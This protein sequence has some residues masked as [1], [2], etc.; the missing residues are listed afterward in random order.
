MYNQLT[1]DQKKILYKAGLDLMGADGY[2][3]FLFGQNLRSD[4]IQAQID[5]AAEEFLTAN[6]AIEN[7]PES[8]IGNFATIDR[9]D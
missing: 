3:A 8:R 6:S 7:V 4:T 1:P 2:T 9:M 5:K